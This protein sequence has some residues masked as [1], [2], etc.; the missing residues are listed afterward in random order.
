MSYHQQRAIADVWQLRAR[1]LIGRSGIRAA[2]DVMDR[3]EGTDL[4][5]L[6][7]ASGSVAMRT[8]TSTA[9]GF[10]EWDFT[11]R[12][13]AHGGAQTEFDKLLGG[14]CNRMFYGVLNR[15]HTDYARW[16]L[17][18]LKPW[19]DFVIKWQHERANGSKRFRPWGI[20]ENRDGTAFYVFNARAP[21]LVH[22]MLMIDCH[23]PFG[24]PGEVAIR[25]SIPAINERR[26]AAA[27]NDNRPGSEKAA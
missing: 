4:Y 7:T 26:T 27:S 19:R 20:R 22:P 17:I 6:D 23:D 21:M 5:I 25:R 3:K 16:M 14:M 1:E 18:N 12:M 24:Y 10:N 8:R 2:S 13:R 11:I 9:L 15:D